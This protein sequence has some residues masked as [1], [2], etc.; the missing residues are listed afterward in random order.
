[1]GFSAPAGSVNQQEFVTPRCGVFA[2]GPVAGSSPR[3]QA[4]TRGRCLQFADLLV[5]GG[6]GVHGTNVDAGEGHEDSPR[7]VRVASSA[8]VVVVA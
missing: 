7:T 3:P 4:D 1:M 8:V 2:R 5:R 6:V